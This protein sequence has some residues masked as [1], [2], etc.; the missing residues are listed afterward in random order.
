[1]ANAVLITG[2][3]SGFGLLTARL[4]HARGWN[5]VP[6]ARDAGR[7]PPPPSDP[8]RWL[9]LRLD[10][11]DPC[12]VAAATGSALERFGALDALVNNAGIAHFSS[13]EEAGPDA[14]RREFEVSFFGAVAVTREVLPSMRA[15]GGG[16]LVFVSSQWGRTG[17]PGFSGYCAAKFALEGWA[18]AL[19]HEARPFGVRLCIVEPGAFDTGFGERS[20]SVGKAVGDPGSPYAG[21][22]ARLRE[23]F[24]SERNPTGEPVAEAIFCAVSGEGDSRLRIVVGKEAEAWSRARFAPGEEEFLLRLAREKGWDGDGSREVG[25]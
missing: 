12:S 25:P 13:A 14:L 8:G 19:A 17:V 11:T 10:V 1:M 15:R 23:G 22:Y 2:A 24:A 18:E 4:C 3:S 6:T 16:C 21:M 20:L 7:I 9:P 5:V